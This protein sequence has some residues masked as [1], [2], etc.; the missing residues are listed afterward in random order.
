[1]R[2]K[3]IAGWTISRLGLADSERM[4]PFLKRLLKVHNF[5]EMRIPLAIVASDLLSGDSAV[6]RDRGELWVRAGKKVKL[7]SGDEVKVVG[8]PIQG[9]L[10]REVYGSGALMEINGSVARIDEGVVVPKGAVAFAVIEKGAVAAAQKRKGGVAAG[11][12]G[13]LFAQDAANATQNADIKTMIQKATPAVQ[14]HLEKAREI[15][16][17]LAA[18]P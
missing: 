18:T 4:T 12:A 7:K 1:M 6:F 10:L 9:T 13:M 8:P 14:K 11:R 2:F 16:G 17:R 5:E 3:D 15:R